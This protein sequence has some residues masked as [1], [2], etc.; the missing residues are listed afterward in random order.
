MIEQ[1]FI[2]LPQFNV[3]HNSVNPIAHYYKE[4]INSSPSESEINKLL[5]YAR[6]TDFILTTFHEIVNDLNYDKEKFENLNK[7]YFKCWKGSLS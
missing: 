6:Q 4:H 1:I 3:Y 5:P 7:K 2:D